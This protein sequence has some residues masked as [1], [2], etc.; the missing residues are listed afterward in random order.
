MCETEVGSKEK[1]GEGRGRWMEK[2]KRDKY[3]PAT[4]VSTAAAQMNDRWQKAQMHRRRAAAEATKETQTA[5][6]AAIL[7]PETGN[8]QP[9]KNT[10]K[11]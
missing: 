9:C 3:G 5:A 2:G 1:A 7:C 8:I 6:N 4:E 11:H 10:N